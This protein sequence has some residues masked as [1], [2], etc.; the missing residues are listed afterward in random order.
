MALGKRGRRNRESQDSLSHAT[1]YCEASLH[2][3]LIFPARKVF[4]LFTSEV[5]NAQDRPWWQRNDGH[6]PTPGPGSMSPPRHRHP[7]VQRLGRVR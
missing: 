1:G 7:S 4:G 2:L 5:H 3:R 6:I